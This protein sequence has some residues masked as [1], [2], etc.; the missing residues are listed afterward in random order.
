MTKYLIPALFILALSISQTGYAQ[1][2]DCRKAETETEWA[3]CNTPELG[4][5]DTELAA[6]YRRVRASGYGGSA[7]KI[8]HIQDFLDARPTRSMQR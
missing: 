5:L 4:K 6:T 8:D 1:S 3:V 7:F 2:F